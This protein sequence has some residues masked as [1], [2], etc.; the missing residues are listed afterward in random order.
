MTRHNKD[1]KF[2]LDFNGRR[3]VGCP[4]FEAAKANRER[5]R[6]KQAILGYLEEE[7]VV[8]HSP[9]SKP[10][11]TKLLQGFLPSLTKED[12]SRSGRAA[13]EFADLTRL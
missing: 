2:L 3:D 12:W 1:G 8:S 6:N 13:A 7:K 9:F 5:V 4:S 10:L 11:P